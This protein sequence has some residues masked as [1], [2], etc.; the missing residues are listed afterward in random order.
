MK[1]LVITSPIG[2]RILNLRSQVADME[3]TRRPN[4]YEDAEFETLLK[5]EVRENQ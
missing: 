2:L 1:V 5:K 4:I 3:R